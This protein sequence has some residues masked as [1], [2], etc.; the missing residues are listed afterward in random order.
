MK[1]A[2]AALAAVACIA[3]VEAKEVGAF[4][5]QGAAI[6]LF[7]EQRDCPV[8]TTAALYLQHNMLVKGCWFEWEGRVN[9]GFED[10]DAYVIPR[11]AFKPK[12][13]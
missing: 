12:S 1:T 13:T 10:G 8:G 11:G 6:V 5:G 2:M 9:L 3:A 7:D 4:S